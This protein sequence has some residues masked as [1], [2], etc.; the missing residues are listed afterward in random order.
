MAMKA[1]VR[2]S[3]ASTLNQIESP[4]PIAPGPTPRASAMRRVRGLQ[5]AAGLI[6]II[7]VAVLASPRD[8]HGTIIFLEL[9]I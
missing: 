3:Q 1:D 2:M 5:S 8:R 4:P 6:G 9:G 7:L